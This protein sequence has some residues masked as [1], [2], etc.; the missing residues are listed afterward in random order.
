MI[1]CF[2]FL[3]RC[4]IRS[5]LFYAVRHLFGL[6][7]PT[8]RGASIPQMDIPHIVPEVRL[9][10]HGVV[11]VGVRARQTA[12]RHRRLLPLRLP[13]EVP[14]PNGH[15]RCEIFDGCDIFS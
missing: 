14:Q 5:V 2:S 10:G 9:R 13:E 6:F 4:D 12:L 3:E 15:G 11:R 1:I 7:R 8:E